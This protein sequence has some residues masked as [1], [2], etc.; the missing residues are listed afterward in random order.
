MC[1]ASCKLL[2][3]MS[4]LY[5]GKEVLLRIQWCCYFLLCDLISLELLRI[6]IKSLRLAD[7]I[8]YGC[9]LFKDYELECIKKY[10]ELK[11]FVQFK[12]N[13]ISLIYKVNQPKWFICNQGSWKFKLCLINK[14]NQETEASRQHEIRSIPKLMIFIS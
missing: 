13:V 10:I 5:V 9:L 7:G 6:L 11:W 2:W 3:C 8:K 4:S 1:T 14:R 12:V